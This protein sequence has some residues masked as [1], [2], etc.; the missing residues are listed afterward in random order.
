M[1]IA[2]PICTIQVARGR[3]RRLPSPLSASACIRSPLI[4]AVGLYAGFLYGYPSALGLLDSKYLGVNLG[5]LTVGI[6][7]SM[8]FSIQ[9]VGISLAGDCR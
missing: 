7:A 3:G 9:L 5:P 6:G 8:A 2:L 4:A 1:L